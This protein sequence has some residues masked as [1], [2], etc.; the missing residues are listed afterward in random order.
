DP[1]SFLSVGN[2][3]L[4]Y[5]VDCSGMQSSRICLPGK[6]PLCT[7]ASWGLHDYSGKQE[8]HYEQL[9]LKYYDHTGRRVG[10]MSDSS[11]QEALFEDLRVNPH[12]FNLA[13]IGFLATGYSQE[14]FVKTMESVQQELD[15]WKGIITSRFRFQKA[16]VQVETF[17]HPTQD[18]LSFRI[19]SSLLETGVLRLNLS[20]PYPS[21][22]I[23]GSD[24]TR[25]DAH[26]SVLVSF[27]SGGYRITRTIDGVCYCVAIQLSEGAELIQKGAHDFICISQRNTMEADVLFSPSTEKHDIVSHDQARIAC[28]QFWYSFWQDGGFV[29]FSRSTDPRA[30]ELQR[31]MLLSRYLLAIQCS[32]NTPPPETGLTC[33]SWYGKFHL[34]MHLLHAAHFALFG[35]PALLERSLSYY[36]DIL[37]GA[38]VRAKEQGY[39]GARWPKMS[40]PSGNDSPSSIG[41][42]LCWQQPHPIFYGS[43][44]RKTN[45]GSPLLQAWL[46]IVKATAD[47][48]VDYVIWDDERKEYVI[49]PPMIPVQ[50]NHDPET[51]LNPTFELSYWR[52]AL[53]EAIDFVEVQGEAVD[54]KWREVARHLAPLPV[55][56]GVYLAHE[57]CP[58]TYEAFAYDHPSF[59]FS[60]GLLDGND[61]DHAIMENSLRKVMDSWKLDELWG[62][63]FPLMAMTAARLG[64]PEL[65]INLL[66]MDSPKNTYTP[67]GHNAQ[68]PKEDLPLYL[69]GNGALLL[70]IS[71]LAGGWEGCTSTHPGFPQEG[72]IVETEGL[73]RFW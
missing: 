6:T 56:D 14:D 41:T 4:A 30:R 57:R 19:A 66:L 60:F 43:L 11:G 61:V 53:S 34:E 36:L 63:D 72:W 18:Q 69:P 71:L 54:Q 22:Q 27:G 51:I 33:N 55:R 67:N 62:W 5:T 3:N 45:P 1:D 24:Y 20:F 65:S 68:R 29:D 7:M 39:Q 48:M 21:H 28:E 58:D 9:R 44:L 42:L 37:P 50:E 17:C 49:G 38:Y 70:A 73:K 46:P 10:Y 16:S 31:R 32:G 12:R 47:F 25:P 13:H 40:D 64:R 2:G 23:D 59:L 52:W 15:L 8:K 35:Q 26:H